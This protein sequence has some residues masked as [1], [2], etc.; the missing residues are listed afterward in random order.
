MSAGSFPRRPRQ[1][2]SATREATIDKAN[3]AVEATDQRSELSARIVGN[4]VDL[5]ALAADIEQPGPWTADRLARLVSRLQLL[6]NRAR[7]LNSVY[8]AA[9]RE[10]SSRLPRPRGA[11]ELVPRLGTRIFEARSQA[12]GRISAAARPTEPRN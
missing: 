1:R 10:S 9:I 2:P 6:E 3:R 11:K 4:N 12:Q 8:A 7:D 5:D